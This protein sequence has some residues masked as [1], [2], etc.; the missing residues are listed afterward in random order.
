MTGKDIYT[1]QRGD[2]L[3]KISK[4]VLGSKDYVEQLMEENNLQA[5]DSIYPGQE[6]KI[7]VIK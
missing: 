4:A 5:G 7:P 1:V 2:T 6:L 3:T